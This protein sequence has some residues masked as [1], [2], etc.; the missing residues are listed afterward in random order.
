MKDFFPSLFLSAL[1]LLLSATTAHAQKQYSMGPGDEIRLTVYNQ[2]DLTTEGQISAD[3][4]MEIPLLGSV[5]LAGRSSADA[6]RMIAEYYVRGDL[7]QDAHVNILITKY[8]SQSVSV[9]G[10]VNS[11]GRLMLEGPMSL[12]QALASSGGVAETGSER[13]ILI[14]TD[15]KGKQ[16]RYEYDLQQLL[17][18]EAEDQP[19]VWLQNG[20]T[21]Y[22]P[23]AGRFYLSGEVRSPG[24]YPLDRKLNVMQALGVGGGPTARANAK[25]VKLYRRQ[26][27]GSAKELRAK[28]DDP[29]LDGDV[30][31]IQESLF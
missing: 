30:L 12:T 1:V 11:P 21:L 28:P 22:V 16:E 14:R 29:V 9:L 2:P 10:K 7:L 19:I 26:P 25:A 3:G 6:A 8:R 17:N 31:V 23:V 4:T 15:N 13:L 5:Q 20:D 24:M 27:D 18:H